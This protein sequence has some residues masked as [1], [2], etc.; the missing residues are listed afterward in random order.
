MIMAAFR[1]RSLP[2]LLAALA[3]G[4]PNPAAPVPRPTSSTGDPTRRFELDQVYLL[5]MEGVP[6]DDTTLYV[7]P[8]TRRVVVLRHGPPDNLVFADVTLP[9]LP[10]D[11]T[12]PA[13]DSVK[14][15]VRPRPGVYGVDVEIGSLVLPA[16]TAVTFEYPVHFSAPEDARRRYGSDEAFEAALAVGQLLP[17]GGVR[18]LV[19]TR[20]TA[21]NLRAELPEPGS[22]VVGAPK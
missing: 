1:L 13:P 21:D 8:G 16:G 15:A 14:L 4:A 3:C 6:P 9:P 20:P 2:A 12:R 18:F 11:T 7:T 17:D 19:S 5:E 10:R 22:Y